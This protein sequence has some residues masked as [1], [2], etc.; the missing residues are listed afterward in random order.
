VLLALTAHLERR[1]QVHL[2]E[3]VRADRLPRLLAHRGVGRHE[4]T[5][6]D[7]PRLVHEPRDVDRPAQVLGPLAS[8]EA[9]PAADRLAHLPAVEHRHGA[10]LSKSRRSSA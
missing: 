3:A 7:E 8:R 9:E 10:P 4:G 6:A 5:D 2:D 1:R